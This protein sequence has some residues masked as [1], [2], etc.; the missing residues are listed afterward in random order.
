[1][2]L[3]NMA[4]AFY[5][6]AQEKVA[7]ERRDKDNKYE[8]HVSANHEIGA[9]KERFV[10]AATEPDG[11]KRNKLVDKVIGQ[12]SGRVTPFSPNRSV[13]GNKTPRKAKFHHNQKSNC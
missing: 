8:Y 5:W 1:M 7:E 10:A 2:Y 3:S 12:L 4:S 6:E 9:L 11:V 13:P